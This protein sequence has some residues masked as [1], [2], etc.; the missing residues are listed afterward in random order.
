MVSTSDDRSEISALERVEDA[1][2]L[3]QKR[4]FP[5]YVGFLDE[6]EQTRLCDRLPESPDVGFSFFGGYDGAQR[7]FFAVYP[8]GDEPQAAEYPLCALAFRYRTGKELTHRDFLGAMLSAG[9][10][11]DAIGDILCGDGLA[12]AFVR[13]EIAAYIADNICTVGR[14]GVRIE[15]DYDGDLPV[16]HGFVDIHE[17]VASPRLDA[18]VKALIGCSREQSARMIQA[19]LVSLEH[20][21]VDSVSR[22]L[23]AP[24]TVS[25]RGYGRFSVDQLGPETKKGRLNLFARKYK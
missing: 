13:R 2:R 12:V 16:A 14:E 21:P 17:T 4:C 25:V 22:V 9:V 7:R 24:V 8:A 15:T 10:R 19:G 1:V 3:C 18:V 23:T 5:C 6:A 11:R 20:R